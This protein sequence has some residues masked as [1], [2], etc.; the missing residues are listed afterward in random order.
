MKQILETNR[1]ILRELSTAD[2]KDFYRL[3]SDSEVMKYT[4][5]LPFNSE[6]DAKGFLENYSAYKDYGYGRWAVILKDTGCFIGWC[7]LKINEENLVD[8]GFRF[9]KEQW[10]KGYA[11]EAAKASIYYGF[12]KIGL[13][14]II[15]RSA[16]KNY[17]SI[18][19]L[20]KIGM[21]F[22]KND[23]CKGIQD[24]VYYKITRN[25]NLN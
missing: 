5:D 24:S 23:S 18:R 3:N 6:A 20:E 16:R 21:K 7:G 22:W 25:E 12:E 17:G 13:D 11:T 10:G 14:Q 19:V 15:G 2:A 8:L 9:F 1:L 4:G